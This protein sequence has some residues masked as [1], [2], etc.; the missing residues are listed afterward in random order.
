MALTV[1]SGRVHTDGVI[2]ALEAAGLSVGDGSGKG[3]TAPYCVVYTDLGDLDGPMGDR[4]ADAEQ[5]FFV[6]SIGLDRNGAQWEADKARVALLGT[7]ITVE[8]RE[9]MYVNPEPG[10]SLPVQ[11][12]DDIQP[13]LYYAVDEYVLA[14][15]PA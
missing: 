3:L 12:D 8:G 2:A 15:T 4:F 11:R 6:H 10:G 13:P 7:P 9:V 1:P 14:T 5:H